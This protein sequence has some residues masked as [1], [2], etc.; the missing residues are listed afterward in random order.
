MYQRYTW[1]NQEFFIYILLQAY[2]VFKCIC[3]T[4]GSG[5]S[6]IERYGASSPNCFKTA[7]Y[8]VPCGRRPQRPSWQTRPRQETRPP[9]SPVT[10]QRPLD[11]GR[12]GWSLSQP[13]APA[14]Q[15][16][17]HPGS[18]AIDRRRNSTR[19]SPSHQRRRYGCKKRSRS[20]R[21]SATAC[22]QKGIDTLA[23]RNLRIHM[24]MRGTCVYT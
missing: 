21:T 8:I 22:L 9:G 14:Q 5:L 19:S 10:T 4:L 3:D 16:A 13:R 7:N 1:R 6:R 11:T 12:G 17:S 23:R 15:A 2:C 24:P 18:V 20:V